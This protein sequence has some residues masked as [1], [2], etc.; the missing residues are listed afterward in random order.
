MDK[1]VAE[2]KARQNQSNAN[3][4]TATKPATDLSKYN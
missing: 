1:A 2:Q 3:P 4:Y